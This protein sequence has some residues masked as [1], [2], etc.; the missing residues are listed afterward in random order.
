MAYPLDKDAIDT[1]RLL[2]ATDTD[3]LVAG[4]R[5]H[6]AEPAAAATTHRALE[7]LRE[8]RNRGPSDD[9]YLLIERGTGGDATALAQYDALVDDLIDA[10]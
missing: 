2:V 4:F 5:E 7:F 8:Q 1:L 3:Q 10:L 9:V 6:E